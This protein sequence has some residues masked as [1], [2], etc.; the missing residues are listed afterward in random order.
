[1]T[2]GTLAK[3]TIIPFEESEN[4]QAG[5][6][7]EPAF[8]AQ[9]NPETFA[10]NNE[11][12]YEQQDPAHGKDGGEAKFKGIKPRI[13]TFELLLDGTGASGG[14][15]KDVLDQFE[16]FKRTVGF[17]GKIHRP[18]FLVLNWGPHIF[19]SALQSFSITYKLFKPDGTP[20]RATLTASFI[21]HKSNESRELESN[22]S[23][24][25]IVHSHLV[26]EGE[27]LS[28]ICHRVYKDPRYYFDVAQTNNLDNL[29]KLETGKTVLLYPLR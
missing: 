17:S 5:P 24:P 11:I 26:K 25:D 22:V 12:E 29:R 6:P 10:L 14:E 27:H 9:F 13:F 2:D 4:V 28:L 19:T 16:S 3:L 7:A 8:K 23:S 15:K 20:L 1:M 18:R 21:E